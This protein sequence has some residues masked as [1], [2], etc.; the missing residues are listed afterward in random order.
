MGYA[1]EAAGG[2]DNV[3]GGVGTSEVA[4][5]SLVPV[6]VASASPLLNYEQDFLSIQNE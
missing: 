2:M 5:R 6:R 4:R 1:W 3:R